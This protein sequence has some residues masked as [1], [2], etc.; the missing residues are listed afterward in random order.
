MSSNKQLERFI[1]VAEKA[2][3]SE[4]ARVLFLTQPAL[5]RQ[6]HDLET[7]LGFPLF[8]RTKTGIVL[9]EMGRSFYEDMKKIIQLEE[10][11]IKKAQA[12][13]SKQEKII[14]LGVFNKVVEIN[15]IQSGLQNFA[16]SYPDVMVQFI[17]TPSSFREKERLL[18]DNLIDVFWREGLEFNYD[19]S[20]LSFVELFQDAACILLTNEH[21]LASREVIY[22]ED[23]RGW[24]LTVPQTDEESSISVPI[25]KFIREQFPEIHVEINDLESSD[26]LDV[27][28]GNKLLFFGSHFAKFIPHIRA[29]PF[30]IDF[31][32]TTFGLVTKANPTK[33]VRSFV[34]TI[35]SSF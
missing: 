32:S 26:Y 15:T 21:P 25:N 33:I 12:L 35:A 22:P 29:I 20:K 31:P 34:K 19:Q 18:L 16:K 4:A 6:I 10:D 5:S 3:I 13:A 1:T 24:T 17:K 28:N 2:S 14:R 30:L 9:T 7:E 27:Q 8:A 11:A 23:L